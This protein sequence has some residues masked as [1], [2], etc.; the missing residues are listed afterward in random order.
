M[1]E[2]LIGLSVGF[3]IMYKRNMT[4]GATFDLYPNM[5]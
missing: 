5:G 3:W 1:F 4:N 2:I